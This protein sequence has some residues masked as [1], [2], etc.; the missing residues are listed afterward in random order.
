MKKIFLLMGIISLMTGMNACKSKQIEQEVSKSIAIGN[1]SSD[2]LDWSGVYTGT[3]PC[4][5][6]VGIQMQITLNK[7]N[8][9]T[10][11]REYLG[12]QAPVE[13]SSGRLVWG[14]NGNTV[15][16]TSEDKIDSSIQFKTGENTLTHLDQDGK[17]ITGRWANSY[18]LVKV[19]PGLVEK[20][21]KLVEIFGDPVVYENLNA[22]EAYIIFK[23]E[24]GQVTGNSGCNNIHG[25]YQ[26]N[27]NRLSFS[28]MVATQMMCVNMDIETKLNRVFEMTDSYS[29]ND[30][31]LILNRARMAPLAK[32]EA[33]YMQ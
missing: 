12:K 13:V 1:N 15:S 6:C 19:T 27:G 33:V 10:L 5:D 17:V 18:V 7:D 28:R 32:F 24:D 8:T 14:N 23:E 29:L 2:H 21:W 3:I 9:Y 25:S 20:H 26:L 31:T 30:N 22:K 11:R 4:A 16:L